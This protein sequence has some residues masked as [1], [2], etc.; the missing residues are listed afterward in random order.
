MEKEK[1]YKYL[2]LLSACYNILNALI[3]IIISLL[4][5]P[6]IF[7]MFGVL[8]PNSMVWLQLSLLLILILGLGYIIVAMDIS[9]NHGLVI[10]GAISKVVFCIITIIYLALGEVGIMV[11]LLGGVDILFVCLFVE[12]LLRYNK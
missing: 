1:Y 7:T 2:F 8:M 4:K 6:A 11:V 9:Q 5:D 10:I 3:F 12:F